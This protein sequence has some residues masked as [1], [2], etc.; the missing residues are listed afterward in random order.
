MTT[1]IS[2]VE[3]CEDYNPANMQEYL[4][5]A[6]LR[7]MEAEGDGWAQAVEAIAHLIKSMDFEH[8]LQSK[9]EDIFFAK[10][11]LVCQRFG[12]YDWLAD[13]RPASVAVVYTLGCG[14]CETLFVQLF[15]D[16]VPF[17]SIALSD[18]ESK[19]RES[20]TYTRFPFAT[21]P[22]VKIEGKLLKGGYYDYLKACHGLSGFHPEA[23]L[24]N[25]AV[26]GFALAAVLILL[27]LRESA[28]LPVNSPN[29]LHYQW[30][31]AISHLRSS[32]VGP[33]T[34]TWE[35]R[36][37]ELYKKW[38]SWIRYGVTEEHEQI[39]SFVNVLKA[40]GCA[41]SLEPYF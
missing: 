35:L 8:A 4:W 18:W 5:W 32:L 23:G 29:G 34:A 14:L 26:G 38:E 22:Q 3:L 13:V 1:T 41:P 36:S 6:E 20:G 11:L 31:D 9:Q 7:T 30:T 12:T 37:S 40:T 10:C 27:G 28:C 21:V 19:Q 17:V 33:W 16:Q 25:I 15:E 24:Q 2:F 39:R